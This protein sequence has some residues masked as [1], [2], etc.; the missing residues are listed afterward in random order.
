MSGIYWRPSSRA[1]A[2]LQQQVCFFPLLRHRR[3]SRSCISPLSRAS[4]ARLTIRRPK[5]VAGS[6]ALVAGSSKLWI[7]SLSDPTSAVMVKSPISFR[8]VSANSYRCKVAGRAIASFLI[9][10]PIQTIHLWDLVQKCFTQEQGV[11]AENT[12]S[13]AHVNV[14]CYHLIAGTRLTQTRC[15]VIIKLMQ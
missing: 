7:S 14:L 4:N 10:L 6:Y 2:G 15:D 1:Q 11:R 5:P 12:S 13:V 9:F 8:M 3:L